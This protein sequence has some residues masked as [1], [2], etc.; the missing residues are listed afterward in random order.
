MTATPPSKDNRDFLGIAAQA[1]LLFAY[2]RPDQDDLEALLLCKEIEHASKRLR[3]LRKVSE[4]PEPPVKIAEIGV[5]LKEID[6][7]HLMQKMVGPEGLEPQ[8]KRL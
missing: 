4:I 1:G 8:T 3:E 6:L 7:N 5:R 2:C